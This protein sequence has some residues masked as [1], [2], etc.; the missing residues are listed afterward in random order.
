MLSVGMP[1]LAAVLIHPEL[2]P[3][4]LI[5]AIALP[6]VLITG[7]AGHVDLM[8]RIKVATGGSSVVHGD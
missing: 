6:I 4:G 8:V 7:F 1:G 2:R 3:V 5:V